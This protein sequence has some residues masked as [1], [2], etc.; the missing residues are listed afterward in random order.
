MF[1]YISTLQAR[2]VILPTNF[3]V[4]LCLFVPCPSEFQRRRLAQ[5]LPHEFLLILVSGILLENF[6]AKLP[7]WHV[8]AH[9]AAQ[10]RTKSAARVF[11]GFGLRHTTREFYYKIIFVT[12]LNS[13]RP[14]GFAQN[15]C[16]GLGCGILA[17]NFCVSTFL[18]RSSQ[19][20]QIH[21]Q[22]VVAWSCTS[23]WQKILWKTWWGPL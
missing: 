7:L 22:G 17:V 3:C 21:F 19:I 6:R 20:L 18:W 15:G 11:L 14:R 8:H 13:F 9:S 10:T 2:R 1:K 16:P 23:P 12:C 4:Q 5:T